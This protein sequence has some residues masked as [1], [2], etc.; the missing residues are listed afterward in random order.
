MKVY[1]DTNVVSS[2]ARGDMPVDVVGALMH[3]LELKDAGSLELVTSEVALQEINSYKGNDERI[4]NVVYRLLEKV[5]PAPTVP[6][7]GFPRSLF[8]PDPI[9]SQLRAFLEE[10]DALHVFQAIKNRVNVFLTLDGGI[11]AR[12]GEIKRWNMD[13]LKPNELLEKLGSKHE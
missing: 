13:V 9:Y 4:L 1:L 8:F 11:L 3:L 6:L 5:R 10:K 2:I 7:I 12:K